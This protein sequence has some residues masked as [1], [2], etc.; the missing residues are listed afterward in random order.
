M[1]RR[2]AAVI[3]DLDGCL[4]DS[5]PLAI[6]A[7]SQS[8]QEMGIADISFEDVRGRFLG[9]SVRD[10][11]GIIASHTDPQTRSAFVHKFETRLLANFKNDLRQIDG[12]TDLLTA[13]RA[14]GVA[15]AVGTGGSV[16]RM[17]RTLEAAGL[18]DWFQS[19]G[20]SAEQVKN[21]KPAPDL[22]LFAADRL[23]VAPADCVVLEDSPHGIQAAVSAG[24]RGIGFVGGT[25]LDGIRDA[26]ARLLDSKGAATVAADM[27]A[28]IRAIL[29]DA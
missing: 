1:R 8:A 15:M 26:H 17:T 29:P 20:F 11:C 7:I 3:F 5:E 21:G 10:I 14:A 23:G 25:H 27:P 18:S 22:F 9:V 16:K 24:M 4:V 2:P 12:V 19:T 28:V 13:L 6:N